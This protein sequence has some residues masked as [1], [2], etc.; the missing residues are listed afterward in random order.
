MNLQLRL[1]EG[2]SRRVLFHG[3]HHLSLL[4]QSAMCVQLS[5]LG[6]QKESFR[7][8]IVVLV[9]MLRRPVRLLSASV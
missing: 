7:R 8:A 4:D 1:R 9:V 3:F 5:T 6:V 2:K